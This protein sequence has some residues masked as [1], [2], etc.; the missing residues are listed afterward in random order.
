[1]RS[2]ELSISK[3]V[4]K[5]QQYSVSLLSAMSQTKVLATQIIEGGVDSML[6]ENFIY[7]TLRSVRSDR[8]LQHKTIV[9]FMDNAVIHKHSEVLETARR[10]RVNVM[11]NA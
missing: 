7:H 1:M 2:R 4:N 11:F 3:I 8:Q 9:L 5:R 6:F 10:M